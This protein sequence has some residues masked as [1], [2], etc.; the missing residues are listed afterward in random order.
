MIKRTIL[1]L[2]SMAAFLAASA[3]F[4]GPGLDL[5]EKSQMFMYG[6]SIY[7][8][9]L[10]SGAAVRVSAVWDGVISE[11]GAKHAG[12]VSQEADPAFQQY[13]Q[14]GWTIKASAAWDG[15]VVV[16]DGA[17]AELSVVALAPTR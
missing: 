7:V 16:F 14:S 17:T 9:D 2:A 11:S 1:T 4:A 8:W 13:P 5:S 12:A 3:G 10:E 15:H 6:D